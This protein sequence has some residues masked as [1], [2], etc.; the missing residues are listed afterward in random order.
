[1]TASSLQNAAQSLRLVRAGFFV[2]LSI[3]VLALAGCAG[4]SRST[5]GYA[6]PN[7]DAQLTRNKEAERSLSDARKDAKKAEKAFSDLEEQIAQDE[8]R[9]ERTNLS[10][11][12]RT[13]A[14]ERLET[15]RA[16]LRDAKREVRRTD[17]A[18]RRAERGQRRAERTLERAER[19]K[20]LSELA[21]KQRADRAREE[22]AARQ[23]RLENGPVRD[24]VANDVSSGS[25]I[26]GL[27]GSNDPAYANVNDY[28]ARIDGEFSLEAIPVDKVSSN[29]LRQEV[30]YSSSHKPGTVVV[31]TG[32]KYLYVVQPGGMAMRYGIGVG[33]EGF[34]WSGEAHI[35]F[36]RKWPTWTPPVEMIERQPE[37]AKYCADCG[38]MEGGPANPLGA[39][40]LYLVANGEDTLYRLH[41]TPKW[42]SI[43]TAASSGCI[44]LMNQ[45]VIDLY[46]R[47]RTGSKVVVI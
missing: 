19:D 5:A 20:Q 17:R 43:G 27:F 31:D 3:A 40:A 24:E 29:L 47:V 34:A 32:A 46:D 37:L 38:G 10:A 23:A 25:F 16:G 42:D 2:L 15:N 45:D 28:A 26:G 4:S 18:E 39:R 41:G 11:K 22:D 33:R 14:E 35:G 8:K 30:R 21:E 12:A 44:R 9:L 7:I 1:M 36:K 13:R 6:A